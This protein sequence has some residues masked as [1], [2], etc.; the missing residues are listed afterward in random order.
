MNDKSGKFVKHK[1]HANLYTRDGRFY[2]RITVGRKR[3]FRSLRTK[4]IREAQRRL[5]ELQT[6]KTAQ[7][8]R[9]KEPTLHEAIDQ[10][11]AWRHEKRS[12]SKPYSPRTLGEHEEQ[13]HKAKKMFP[14]RPISHFTS[15]DFAE[16]IA[17]MT[18]IRDGKP[19]GASQRKKMLELIKGAYARAKMLNQVESNPLE[20]IVPD[21]VKRRE[22]VLPSK[23]ELASICETMGELF[24]KRPKGGKARSGKGAAL[25][26]RLLAY[27][28]LRLSE[29]QGL[30]WKHISEGKIEV[31]GLNEQLKTANSRR[32]IHISAPLQEV[33]D[34]ISAIYGADPEGGVM[35]N[36]NIRKYLADTCEHLNR[37]KLTHH[38]LR[39]FF[40]TLCIT[41]GVDVNT[42]ANWMGDRVS[43][44]MEVYLQVTE[45]H[46]SANASKIL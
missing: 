26:A 37:P 1:G 18:R 4:K 32:S 22:R 44:V 5:A 2:A 29:A 3:T 38:D 34:E 42:V 19:E 20:G 9:R 11:I 40:A 27:S 43:T 17:N 15:S 10:A 12:A 31:R 30:L 16:P 36:R 6:G 45:D 23:E 41:S 14:D 46:M 8:D 13:R 33:L 39:S 25:T 24:S 28:G 35:P 21:Q 7:A